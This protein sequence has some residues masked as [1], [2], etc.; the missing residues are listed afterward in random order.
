MVRIKV[1]TLLTCF[2][3][4]FLMA[5]IVLPVPR[6]DAS[7]DDGSKIISARLKPYFYRKRDEQLQITILQ[8]S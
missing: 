8:L 3:L 5:F 4:L 1:T 2:F 7:D 6:K